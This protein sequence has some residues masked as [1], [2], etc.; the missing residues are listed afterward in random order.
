M[1]FTLLAQT[2][3]VMTQVNAFLD[4]MRPDTLGDIL[5]YV[6]FSLALI[7]TFTLADGNDMAGNLLYATIVLALFNV[8]VG[9]DWFSHPDVAYAFPAYVARVTMFL[10]PFIAAG[11]ARSK[12]KQGKLALPLSVLTGIVGMVYAVGSFLPAGPV[13]NLMDQPGLF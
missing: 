2:D 5:A 7:T 12:K 1:D 11:A 3:Q 4:T 6:V 10:L 13:G 8:T 9:A